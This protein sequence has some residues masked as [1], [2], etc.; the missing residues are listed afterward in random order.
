MHP[1]AYKRRWSIRR[2]EFAGFPLTEGELK[3]KHDV[4]T[5]T[6]PIQF[7]NNC[8]FLGEIPM[9]VVFEQ[10]GNFST[11]LDEQLTKIEP[12]ED[13]YGIAITTNNGLFIMTGCGHRGIC[14]V[15]EQAKKLHNKTRSGKYLVGSI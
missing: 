2:N 12:T 7:F 13:D 9:I 1:S 4:I 15:I 5:S 3:I 11:T 10:K 8:Y 6:K 14:N